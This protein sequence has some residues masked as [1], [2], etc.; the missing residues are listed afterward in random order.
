MATYDQPTKSGSTPAPTGNMLFGGIV[1]G[2]TIAIAAFAIFTAGFDR[3]FVLGHSTGY[4]AL[5]CG[6]RL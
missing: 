2:L 1:I 4:T 3:C 5:I 6:F